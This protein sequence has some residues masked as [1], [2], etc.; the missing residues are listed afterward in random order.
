MIKASELFRKTVLRMPSSVKSGS[1]A[2]KYEWIAREIEKAEQFEE[3]KAKIQ[4][5]RDLA[6]ERFN[7]E[8]EEIQGSC[9]HE[10]A[11]CGPDEE[12]ECVICGYVRSGYRRS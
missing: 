11:G 12:C 2:S 9:E 7:R 6:I 3:E 10:F 8:L 1:A 4:K 5:K